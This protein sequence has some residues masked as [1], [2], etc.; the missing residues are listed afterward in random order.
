M[1]KLLKEKDE[2]CRHIAT[3]LQTKNAE[4]KRIKLKLAENKKQKSGVINRVSVDDSINDN[5]NDDIEIVIEKE[6]K[7]NIRENRVAVNPKVDSYNNNSNNDDCTQLPPP[8]QSPRKLQSQAETQSNLDALIDLISDSEGDETTDDIDPPPISR[9]SSFTF[10]APR[11]Q[12]RKS[13][14]RGCSCCDKVQN[15]DFENVI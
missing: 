12:K 9:N 11:I 2:Q 6:G 5:V 10:E 8:P 3:V 4:W 7:E 13:H 14:A 1:T 15:R